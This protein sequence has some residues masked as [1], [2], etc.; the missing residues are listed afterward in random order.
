MTSLDT[1]PSSSHVVN[2]LNCCLILFWIHN[3]I[4]HCTL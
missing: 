2:N 4:R 3:H 1:L